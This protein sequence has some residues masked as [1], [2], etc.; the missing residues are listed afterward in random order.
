[1]LLLNELNR[2]KSNQENANMKVMKKLEQIQEDNT[3]TDAIAIEYFERIKDQQEKSG[4][5]VFERLNSLNRKLQEFETIFIQELEIIKEQQ[6]K[7][8][9]QT[10]DKI[11]DVKDEQ[12]QLHSIIQMEVEQTNQ[13]KEE[14]KQWFEMDHQQKEMIWSK[15]NGVEEINFLMKEQLQKFQE[16]NKLII[17][18][19]KVYIKNKIKS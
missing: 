18:R 7:T 2:V 12:D 14:Q 1:M 5:I 4:A 9:L 8:E 3:V 13:F 10:T 15:M 17:E 6:Q 16:H 19:F 11:T